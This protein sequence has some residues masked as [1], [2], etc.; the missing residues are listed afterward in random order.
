[1]S[2]WQSSTSVACRYISISNPLSSL[3]GARQRR[4]ARWGNSDTDILAML[5]VFW[6]LSCHNIGRIWQEGTFAFCTELALCQE[7]NYKAC[8]SGFDSWHCESSN[9]PNQ[10]TLCFK[11][12]IT[13][14]TSSDRIFFYEFLGGICNQTVAPWL[15]DIPFFKKKVRRA[16][17]CWRK[18]S[19][20][21]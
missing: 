20:L 16:S 9:Q 14:G 21:P 17:T 7:Q 10:N 6:H 15:P 13:N 2:W 18:Y 4:R 12:C 11:L 8:W 19:L 3:N 5:Y 1:M